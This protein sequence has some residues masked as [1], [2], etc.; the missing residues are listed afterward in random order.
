MNKIKL[1]IV[2][3]LVYG[4]GG[5]INKIVPLLM[6]PIV[7][8][9]MPGTEYF[10]ISDLSNTI[11]QFASAVAIIGMYDAMYR[12]FFDKDEPEFKKSV[13]ST[14]LCFTT[15]MS[16][17][18]CA[19]MIGFK[20]IIAI[21]IFGNEKYD[22]LSYIAAMTVLVSATNSIVSA[23]TR[24]ENKKTIFLITNTVSPLLS[25]SISIPLILKGYYVIALP[26]AGLLAGISL[27]IV[28]I[29]LN[30]KWFSIKLF[31]KKLL[32][33]LLAI[34]IPLF[35]NF[36]IYWVFNSSDKLMITNI[37][38]VG[39]AG[40]YSVGAKL[41]HVSQLIYSAFSGGWQYFAF[42][43][44]NEKNQVKSNSMIFEYLGV[45]SYVATTFI[46]AVSYCFY[47]YVF[48][49]QYIDGYIIAP[50]LFLAPL[51]QMLFQVAA[52]Q[53]LVVK[54]TWPNMLI[55]SVGAVVNVIIN[56][57]LIPIIGIEGA[58]I[59]TLIGYVL[60]DIICV[61]VLCK[62]KL[63]AISMK[64]IASTLCMCLYFIAWRLFI[65]D[66][67]LIGLISAVIF[68]LL[69]MLI[70][71]NDIMSLIRIIK[72]GRSKKNETKET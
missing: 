48:A 62:M 31:D 50:Y 34:A 40:I 30:R 51:L 42:S 21:Y 18:V 36:L 33:P 19:I 38:S 49:K 59:A 27:E 6:L 25:Y 45:I 2:N 29:I 11:I 60:S 68:T 64:F 37:L 10:G 67:L 17:V 4:L 7:T 3:F 65:T 15:A 56:F 69:I 66:N 55:L 28:F 52:N 61:L 5:I 13:C 41:G 72:S 46:C 63:M 22:Y 32:K 14:T 47:K 44:M 58:A 1:F 35:P 57:V 20:G 53:F 71:K 8:R 16:I 39:A 12:L 9:L 24:M 54:K 23:P 26:L 70:Y 43:T